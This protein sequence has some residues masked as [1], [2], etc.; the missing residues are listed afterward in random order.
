MKH[1]ALLLPLLLAGCAAPE[2]SRVAIVGANLNPGPGKA[3][4]PDSI[5]IVNGQRIE[6]AGPQA[7]TPMPKNARIIRAYGGVVRPFA[8]EEIVPGAPADLTLIHG[9]EVRVMKNGEWQQS[10]G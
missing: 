9:T 8:G 1:W 5:V 4:V 7:T 10:G 3:A 6:A 2:M